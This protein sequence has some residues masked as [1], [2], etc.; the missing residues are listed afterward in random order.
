MMEYKLDLREML[1]FAIGRD[2]DFSRNGVY[3]K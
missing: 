2:V 3:S 1:Y